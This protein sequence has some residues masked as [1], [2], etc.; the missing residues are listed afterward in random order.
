MIQ[1]QVVDRNVRVLDDGTNFGPLDIATKS[2]TTHINSATYLEG[3]T[4]RIAATIFQTGHAVIIDKPSNTTTL[5]RDGLSRPHGFYR[6]G[7]DKA[8]YVI[9]SPTTGLI[10]I[11]DR[12]YRQTHTIKG[13]IKTGTD[14]RT[15]LQNT[16]P[17]GDNI[18]ALID[19]YNF[20]VVFFDLVKRQKHVVETHKQWKIFQLGLADPQ[21]ETI[22]RGVK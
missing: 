1:G 18:L 6:F 21:S 15:W 7:G 12:D 3:S 8:Q 9:T 16:F 19:H 2:Q 17:V 11:L 14:E 13:V 5:V 22:L 20:H 4:D 10:E